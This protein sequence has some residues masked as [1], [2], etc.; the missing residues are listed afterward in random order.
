MIRLV[1]AGFNMPVKIRDPGKLNELANSTI[2]YNA[3]NWGY[4]NT[5]NSAKEQATALLRLIHKE[6]NLEDE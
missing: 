5:L 3:H 6:Y 2:N 4:A 1:I